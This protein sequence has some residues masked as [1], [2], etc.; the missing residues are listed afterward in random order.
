MFSGS[1]LEVTISLIVHIL[2]GYKNVLKNT[3]VVA[4]LT[5]LVPLLVLARQCFEFLSEGVLT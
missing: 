2:Y 4:G 3:L 1:S 5:H